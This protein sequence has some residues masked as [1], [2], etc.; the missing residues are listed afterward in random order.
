MCEREG[1]WKDKVKQK[2]REIKG[3]RKRKEEK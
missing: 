3:N 1:G 2:W